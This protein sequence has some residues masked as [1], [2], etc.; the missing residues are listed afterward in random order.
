MNPVNRWTTGPKSVA[1]AVAL[2]VTASS[3]EAALERVGP[4]SSAPSIGGFPTWYM[5]TTGLALE[6]CDPRNASEIDGGWC[7]LLPGDPPAVPEVFPSLFFD[8]HFYFAATADVPTATG[9]TAML[10]MALESAFAVGA[11]VPGDQVVFSR[12]RYILNPAPVTG[13][14]RFITPY[15]ERSIDALAGERIFFT[16]DVGFTLSL[17]HI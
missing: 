16:D 2:A 13:T 7:L 8:E 14:Y 12:I 17:I 3:A 5:D 15:G 11:P 4:P 1:L 6:F 9:A 10:V